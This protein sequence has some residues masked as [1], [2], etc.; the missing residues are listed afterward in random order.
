MG[1]RCSRSN[2]MP[3]VAPIVLHIYDVGLAQEVQQVNNILRPF[4]LGA[5]HCGVEVYG[6]EWSFRGKCGDDTMSSCSD[7]SGIFCCRPRTSDGHVYREAIPMGKTAFSEAEVLDLIHR[8]QDE[9]LGRSYD[10]LT[11]NCCHFSDEL[12]RRLGVGGVPSWVL[13]LAGAGAAVAGAGECAGAAVVD[14]GEYVDSSAKS[15]VAC[16][17]KNVVNWQCCFSPMCGHGEME[18]D[19]V[20]KLKS[21]EKDGKRSRWNAVPNTTAGIACVLGAQP[22]L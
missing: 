1:A 17:V 7:N 18:M 14:F 13:N 6:W 22:Y 11:K 5:F 21:G 9:W 10:I 20:V 4:G 19:E 12:C 2:H 15:L 3:P 16:T 8:L